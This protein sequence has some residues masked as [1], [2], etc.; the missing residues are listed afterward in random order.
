[1]SQCFDNTLI[2]LTESTTMK[3][4]AMLCGHIKRHSLR[5]AIVQSSLFDRRF[6]EVLTPKLSIDACFTTR[7]VE[8]H[9]PPLI[10]CALYG[11]DMAVEDHYN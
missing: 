2:S 7:S 1:M 3:V 5:L 6:G 11:D 4:V 10:C 8:S 9:T